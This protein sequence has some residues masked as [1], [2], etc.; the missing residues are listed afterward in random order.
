MTKDVTSGLFCNCQVILEV[1]IFGVLVNTLNN[2]GVSIDLYSFYNGASLRIFLN[3]AAISSVTSKWVR[4]K[5]GESE[6]SV[7]GDETTKTKRCA[8]YLGVK[9]FNGTSRDEF[10]FVFW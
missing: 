10:D 5:M 1:K 8:Y 6:K 4:V 3:F 9:I 7:L 2:N